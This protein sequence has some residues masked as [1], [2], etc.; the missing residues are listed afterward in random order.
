ML[1]RRLIEILRLL[2]L[3]LPRIAVSNVDLET[4]CFRVNSRHHHMG[5]QRCG[6]D[7]IHHRM[8]FHRTGRILFGRRTYCRSK[9]EPD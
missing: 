9:L 4:S 3:L 5:F 2:R 1:E 8:G 6:L 7:H